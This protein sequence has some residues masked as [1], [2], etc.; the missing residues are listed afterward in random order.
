MPLFL[1]LNQTTDLSL[2]LDFL[3]KGEIIAF[4]TDT[5]YGIGVRLS[6]RIGIEKLFRIKG[7]SPQKAIAVLI[8]GIDQL[9]LVVKSVP[10]SG[11]RL[12][13][14][15]WPGALTL[16]LPK[17]EDLPENVSPYPTIGVRMPDHSLISELIKMT[18]PLATTSANL[19]GGKDPLSPQDV[20]EQL[21]DNF[22][23]LLDGGMTAGGIPSTVV[24]CTQSPP[25]VLRQG[26]ISTE[27]ILKVVMSSEN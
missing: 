24:D 26:S 19:S 20:L 5:V 21:G 2:A 14:Q 22:G 12:A 23:L 10:P 15:F 17:R 11:L 18:G 8:G 1:P 7:R 3:D 9:P 16:V 27:D 6:S 13:D 4:P 25:V